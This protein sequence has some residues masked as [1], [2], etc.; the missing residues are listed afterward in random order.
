MTGNKCQNG[1]GASSLIVM[2]AFSS[3]M[4]IAILIAGIFRYFR[5][6]AA[7]ALIAAGFMISGCRSPLVEFNRNAPLVNLNVQ[8]SANG[9]TV[10]LVGGQ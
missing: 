9:N 6:I 4:V 7:A 1:T 5:F 3:F 8:D 10:P 2:P